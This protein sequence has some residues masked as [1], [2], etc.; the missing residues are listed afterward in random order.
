[1]A[2]ERRYIKLGIPLDD[3]SVLRWLENQHNMSD[4]VRALIRADVERGGYSDIFCREVTVKGK[5][6]R[7]TNAEVQLR[8]MEEIDSSI[9]G[10]PVRQPIGVQPSPV[11]K[12]TPV[13]TK[14]TSIAKVVKEED[15]F[16]DPEALL[17]F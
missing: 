3:V 11:T 13:E 9:P 17:G 15:E 7:P 1:M 10:I 5:V 6:G 2:I 16:V 12:V 14:Q 8:E 4:S